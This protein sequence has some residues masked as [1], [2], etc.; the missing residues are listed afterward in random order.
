[1]QMRPHKNKDICT[2]TST[3][4]I[5][6]ICCIKLKINL[7]FHKNDKKSVFSLSYLPSKAK[8]Y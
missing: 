8:Q 7:K 1:M 3:T 5:R 2:L 4:F 6:N